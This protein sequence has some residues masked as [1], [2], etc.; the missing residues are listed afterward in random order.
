MRQSED[1]L[2][3]LINNLKFPCCA[4]T[5]VSFPFPVNHYENR[6]LAKNIDLKLRVLL[7]YY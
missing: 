2:K 7:A 4:W 1:R 6:E 5:Y 3:Y